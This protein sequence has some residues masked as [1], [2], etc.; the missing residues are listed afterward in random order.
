MTELADLLVTE[1]ILRYRIE[2]F[3]ENGRK[4]AL[5]KRTQGFFETKSIDLR[6]LWDDYGHI[7]LAI[8]KV[9]IQD[10]TKDKCSYLEDDSYG[11]TEAKYS[12]YMGEIA[13][14]LKKFIIPAATA[15][16]NNTLGQAL[17]TTIIQQES[18]L[19]KITIPKYNGDYDMWRSFHDLFLSL[20]H[21]NTKLSPVQKLYHL[22][23]CLTGDAEKLLRHTPITDADYEPAWI[24]LKE[25]YENK[26]ILVNH[27]LK[28]LVNQPKIIAEKI[29]EMKVLADTTNECLQQLKSLEIDKNS[30]D[31]LLVH[32]LTQKLPYLTLRLWEEEQGT[33]QELPTYSK[34]NV[35]CKKV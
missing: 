13:E 11:K 22:K 30:W 10:K 5:A 4:T 20:V 34:F 18:S 1:A 6:K 7:D 16:V 21:N 27:Q 23:S 19:P 15:P 29:K 17:T 33:S 14:G 9:L 2:K 31:V 35:F 25:R 24:K 32:I 26:R 8:H 28:V 3:I 12:E